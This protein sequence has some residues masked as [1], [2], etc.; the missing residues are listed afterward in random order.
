MKNFLSTTALLALVVSIT[1]GLAHAETAN[2]GGIATPA[3]NAAIGSVD[4]SAKQEVGDK[5][6]EAKTIVKDEQSKLDKKLDKTGKT[7]SDKKAKLETAKTA[8][9]APV[10]DAATKA[11]DAVK[12]TDSVKSSITDAVPGLTK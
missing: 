7:V 1:A 4:A 10:V 12:A 6:T 11:S 8:V 9:T 5:K 3:I 2:V